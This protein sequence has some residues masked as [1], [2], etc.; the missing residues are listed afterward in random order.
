MK[1]V[2]RNLI[3]GNESIFEVTKFKF[4]CSFK[5]IVEDDLGEI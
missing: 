2:R 4:L 1:T 3:S 5:Y